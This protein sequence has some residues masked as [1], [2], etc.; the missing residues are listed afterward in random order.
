[1]T[2]PAPIFVA[3]RLPAGALE[4]LT[5]R[6]L[7]FD[8]NQ[9]D[10]PLSPDDLRRA[11]SG[12]G[13]LLCLVLDRIDA[14]LMDAAGPS[15]RVIATVSVG[16]DHIDLVAARERGI[17]VTHTPDVLTET[18]A[19]LTFALMLAAARRIAELD[20][21]VRDG[22]WT[23]WNYFQFW[24]RDVHGATLGILGGGRIGAAVARRAAG[25]N[26]PILCCTRG[27]S[28]PRMPPQTRFVDLPTLLR[29][30]DFLSIHAP[31]TPQTHHLIGR[32]ELEQMKPTAL[33]INTARGL[34][35]DE[36]A[37]IEAL[38]A[39]RIA[40]AGLD[41]FTN[42]PYVPDA[43]RTMD[44]VVLLPHTGSASRA[45]RETMAC[46][47]AEGIADVLEGRPAKYTVGPPP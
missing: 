12:R 4:L 15:L 25:F 33:L 23:G 31:L 47:A 42:E 44:N 24:G 43:L 18:C 2:P 30:S 34:I 19:D 36:A 21:F 22:R 46:M 7:R 41:V 39:G 27:G 35:I 6:G 9:T 1:M 45:T 8:Q 13:G 14:G 26:M 5:R 32:A 16:V 17:V 10:S 20:R 29:E 38:A 3:A 40:G 37:L 11:A 28:S